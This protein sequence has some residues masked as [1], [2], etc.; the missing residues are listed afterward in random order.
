MKKIYSTILLLALVSAAWAQETPKRPSWSGFVSNGFWDNWEISVGAG[1]GTAL[2]Y[3][4]NHGKFGDRI[5]FEGN[6]SLLKWV[7][8]VAGVRAQLQGGWFNN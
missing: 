2:S 5:G 4:T 1:A 8:P 3:G 7:H 6:F